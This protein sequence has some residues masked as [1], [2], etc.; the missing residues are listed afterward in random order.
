MKR[1][2]GGADRQATPYDPRNEELAR[3]ARLDGGRRYT[4]PG[5][6]SGR[7]GGYRKQITV[8]CQGWRSRPQR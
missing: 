2:H 5:L 7:K 4:N 3:E 1:L 6:F 8:H